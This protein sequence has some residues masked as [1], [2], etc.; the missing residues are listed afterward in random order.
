MTP[1]YEISKRSNGA[2]ATLY[3][4]TEPDQL[5]GPQHEAAWSDELAKWVYARETWDM[6]CNSD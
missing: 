6:S 5:R 2:I 3:N 1:L 4:A